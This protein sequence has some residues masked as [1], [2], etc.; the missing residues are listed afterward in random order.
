MKV[1]LNL[2][3]LLVSAALMS[4]VLI[5]N[6]EA[7]D[8]AEGGRSINRSIHLPANSAAEDVASVNGRIS[9]GA[10]STAQT[11]ETVNG[12]IELGPRCRVEDVQTVNGSLRLAEDVTV[13]GDVRTVNGEIVLNRGV[14]V[15]G[16]V[17]LINGEARLEGARVQ[18]ALQTVS[19]QLELLAGSRV[20]QGLQ[21][22]EA[23]GR[24]EVERVTIVLGPGVVIGGE[25]EFARPVT[26][27]R[28]ASASLGEY[29][30]DD[31][32]FRDYEQR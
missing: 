9:L 12:S 28:H 30:G 16:D 13:S 31:V 14:Q 5:V 23:T 10:D 19:A 27:Y 11:V 17:S 25:S 21:V 6:A 18:G 7:D 24:Q 2:F 1:V 20:E 32:K 22:R 8:W 3:L 4:C 29:R 15:A 26:I